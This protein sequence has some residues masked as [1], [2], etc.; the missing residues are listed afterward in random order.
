VYRRL[1]QD[2]AGFNRF[3][4]SAALQLNHVPEFASLKPERLGAMLIGRWR[5]GAPFLRSPERDNDQLGQTD[6]PNN[7][8]DFNNA[9]DP[10]DGFPPPLADPLGAICPQASHIRK[11][12]PRNLGTDKG[13][14]NSTLVHRILRRG[15]PYGAP[16][17]IGSTEDSAHPDRGLLFLCYQASIRDQFEFI[18]S[19]WMNE[20]AKPTPQFS[21][22]TGSGFDMIVG[23][24]QNSLQQGNRFCLVGHSQSRI[25]TEGAADRRWVL[26]TGGGY[27]FTP[28]LSAI[29]YVLS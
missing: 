1:K 21:P 23:Q 25:S 24:N 18:C 3:L 5:S 11:V 29:R 9:T 6:G 27:F 22:P 26:S 17:P 16:L 12:N 10:H 28:S 7:A 4:T 8:F 2:V 15:I 14:P 13:S 20:G 19:D